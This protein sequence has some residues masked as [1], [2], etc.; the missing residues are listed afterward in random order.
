MKRSLLI[1]RP[2]A[3]F[4]IALTASG[5][6]TAAEIP[7][8]DVDNPAYREVGSYRIRQKGR[9]EYLV[10]R[11]S[12]TDSTVVVEALLPVDERYRM[13]RADLPI[14]IPLD[15]VTQIARTKTS[16]LGT[17]GIVAFVSSMGLF[18]YWLTTWDGISN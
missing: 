8:S 6:T 12:V 7:R 1:R 15:E 2:I 18:L 13:G 5:C 3:V 17:M 14:V 11:F 9:K 10:S 16:V 4:L